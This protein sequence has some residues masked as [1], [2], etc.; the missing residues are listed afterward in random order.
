[1]IKLALSALRL[2]KMQSSSIA[3][4]L[5]VAMPSTAALPT[6]KVYKCMRD[7]VVVFS[8]L[9]CGEGAIKVEV[10]LQQPEPKPEDESKGYKSHLDDVQKYVSQQGKDRKIAKHHKAIERFKRQMADEFGQIQQ[11]R[12]R[13]ADD[14]NKAIAALSK[15]YDGLIRKEQAA[16]EALVKKV[17]E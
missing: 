5:L 10:R 15:K 16:I 3:F 17:K 13:T 7:G 2:A 14:K 6:T 9:S 12:F 8:Q 1:M 11:R 4:L